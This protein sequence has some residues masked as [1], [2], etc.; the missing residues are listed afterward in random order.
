MS[1]HIIYNGE[2]LGDLRTR[3]AQEYELVA[4]GLESLVKLFRLEEN[5]E[6]E[7][8][9]RAMSVVD[10]KKEYLEKTGRIYRDE[11]AYFFSKD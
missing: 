3:G 10:F 2:M 6:V 7:L 11:A 1:S 4:S 8:A 5:E 9:G